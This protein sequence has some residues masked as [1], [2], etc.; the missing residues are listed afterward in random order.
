MQGK[1]ISASTLLMSDIEPLNSSHQEEFSVE[2]GNIAAENP[3]ER[4]LAQVIDKI[5]RTLDLET[6]F[7][8]TVSEVRQLLQAD[9]VAVYR[10][11]TDSNYRGGEIVSEDVDKNFNSALAAKVE[12]HCFAENQVNYYQKGKIWSLE[13]VESSHLP[14]CYRVLLAGFQVQANLVVPLLQGE[15][16]WGLLCI[17]QCAS[18]RKWQES[19]IDF[20]KKI[21]VNLGIAV[22]QAE[23]LAKMRQRS[24]DL[25]I[26]LSQ[27]ESQREHLAQVAAKEQ[28]MARVIERIRQ[29][30]DLETIFRATTEELRQLLQCDRVVV[31]RFYEDYSGEF[32]YE[33]LQPGWRPLTWSPGLKTVWNDTY[34]Q[35]TQGGRYLYHKTFAV[36]DI[37]QANL[38][39]CH[40]AI[41]EQFQVKAFAI[42]PVF[43]GDRLWG[44]LGAY[45]NCQAHE[46]QE[47]EISLL[48]QVGNQLGVGVYQA[49]LLKQTKEQ[50]QEL[51]STLADLSVIVDNLADGLLVNDIGGKITRFNPALLAMFE[52]K[53]SDLRGKYIEEVFPATLVN[54]VK[55]SERS[56]NTVVT[57]SVKLAENRQGQALVS[58]ILKSAQGEEGE[59]CL[60]SVILIRDVTKEREIDRMKTEFLANVSHELR[61]PLTSILGFASLIQEK[62]AEVIF[63][64]LATDN[65]KI[66]KAQEKV[67]QHIDI[68]V[69]E[70]ERLTELITD[71]LDIAKMEA[72]QLNLDLKPTS[73]IEILQRAIATVEPQRAEK[74][75]ALIQNFDPDLPLIFADENRLMQVVI[76]LLSNAIK[77]TEQGLIECRAIMQG[78]HL[79]ISVRDTG[80]GVASD[81]HK[82]IFERFKQVGNIFTNKPK[83]TGLGLPICKQII[84]SHGGKI[85]VES[86]LGKGSTFYFTLPISQET[87]QM[88]AEI[89]SF[90]SLFGEKK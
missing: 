15:H 74:K 81:E 66:Q 22:Q 71:V 77:F 32:C 41:L 53:G 65:A 13:D 78:E 18:P 6:I 69:S 26:A 39:D 47:R 83:G 79:L 30:L 2:K 50:S 64:A 52:L 88:Y 38:A 72:G 80:I 31:Y 12:D 24:D 60:G 75:L 35:D 33:S 85:G 63:P 56:F 10:F 20:I 82:V 54:L 7:Q 87:Q 61:T 36:N 89:K 48:A 55:H 43:V 57:I 70:A 73:P 42:A 9:R 8:T 84:E 23:L 51:Q 37:Y 49:Q 19:E 4:S 3:I 29:T 90:N 76:N 27:V 86:V 28:A 21:A 34:L 17:H 58:S 40:V 5:R 67:G 62:L 1:I 68:I 25:Q 59:Q 14:D 45:H 44:L 11:D 46:W 16:L